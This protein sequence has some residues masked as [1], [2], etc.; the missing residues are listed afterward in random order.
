[1]Q[2]IDPHYE[3]NALLL[4]PITYMNIAG[5]NVAA[6]MK[7]YKVEKSK[8]IILHD[9]LELKVGTFRFVAGTSFK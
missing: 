2:V 1:M 7:K 3:V 6:A 9:E 8:L 5:K 4:R